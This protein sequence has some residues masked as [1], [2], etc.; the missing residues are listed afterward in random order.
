MHINSKILFVPLIIAF[1]GPARARLCSLSK[2]KANQMI[3]N[4]RTS[5]KLKLTIN[6]YRSAIPPRPRCRD[7]VITKDREFR[8]RNLIPGKEAHYVTLYYR[9]SK[10]CLCRLCDAP[11]TRVGRRISG[12]CT[13]PLRRIL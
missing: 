4:F 13:F 5:A 12:R 10:H 6:L 11:I 3:N 1:G 7:L 8:A 2:T 9:N